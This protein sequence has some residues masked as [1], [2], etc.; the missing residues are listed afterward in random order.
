MNNTAKLL[1]VCCAIT[2]VTSCA[3]IPKDIDKPTSF[4]FQD[5]NNTQ[6]G[7]TI[8]PLV[9]N[10][11]SKS[12]LLP[13]AG[14][15]DAFTARYILANA[16]ERSIDAQYYIWH[17]D[18]TGKL[19]VHALL[20]AADRGVRVRLLLDDINM[21]GKDS[22]LVSLHTHPNISIRLFN[23]FANR[24]FRAMDIITDFS[25]INRRMHNKSF[26][27]DN[28]ATIVGGRNIGDEY[29]DANP[30]ADIQDFDF[31]A[32]GDAVNEVSS[33]FDKY[34]NSKFAI[35]I[36][37]LDADGD[38]ETIDSL[39]Q[40]LDKHVA[41]IS[42]TIYVDAIKQSELL[43]N[44]KG[45]KLKLF[46]DEAKVLYD[47]P[48]K[49][50][51]SEDDVTTH[52]RSKLDPLIAGTQQEVMIISPYFIPGDKG[53][54]RAEE[55]EK[56]GLKFR[57]LTNSLASTDVPMVYSSYS[58]YRIPLLKAGVELYEMKPTYRS[59]QKA[60]LMDVSSRASLH[61]KVYIFDRKHIFVGSYN[62]D[63]RSTKINTE[64]GI[65]VSNTKL[66]EHFAQW[67][68]RSVN[69]LAY[70]LVLEYPDGKQNGDPELVW[71]DLAHDPVK[72]YDEEPK[73][74]S[75]EKF[76]NDFLSI[77]PIEG[78]L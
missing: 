7:K 39:K 4:S 19:L 45:K 1:F 48:E 53:V 3:S 27:I 17:A 73:V 76:K 23:P 34:W 41:Q 31:L 56:R 69:Q 15:V 63:P 21:A 49:I 40:K 12:G 46:W 58:N 35:P 2:I 10:Q 26:T 18:L 78:Q 11:G 36:D 29:F 66:A 6:L 37:A 59:K 28:Q 51:L 33:Q 52:L 55:A 61:S 44:V 43:N 16:A 67:W 57:V 64:M 68:E 20:E 77:L 75:W 13:L 32:I 24:S 9:K 71:L 42:N 14:G 47:E 72:R 25:R 60:K 5:T 62:L 74:G 70:K 22:A 54:K 30:T 8:Q 38:G 50:E 65:Y